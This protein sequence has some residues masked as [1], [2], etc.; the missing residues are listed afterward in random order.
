VHLSGD[1]EDVAHEGHSSS[2]SDRALGCDLLL[3]RSGL[4]NGTSQSVFAF[5]HADATQLVLSAK[6]E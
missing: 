1:V 2:L 3:V 6:P 4:L 5:L